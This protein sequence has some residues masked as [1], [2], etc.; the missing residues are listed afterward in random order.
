MQGPHTPTGTLR[1]LAEKMHRELGP[2]P[3]PGPRLV[4]APGREAAL[5]VRGKGAFWEQEGKWASS[6]VSAFMSLHPPPAPSLTPDG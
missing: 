5:L 3:H 1:D 2:H 4:S 6:L